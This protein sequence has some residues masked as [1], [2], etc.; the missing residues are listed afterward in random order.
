[1]CVEKNEKMC[2]FGNKLN[3]C[4]EYLVALLHLFTFLLIFYMKKYNL[5]RECCVLTRLRVEFAKMS[6]N[7]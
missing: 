1:M 4:F 3:K 6:D 5:Y 7:I 2:I